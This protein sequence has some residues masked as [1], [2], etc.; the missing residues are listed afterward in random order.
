MGRLAGPAMALRFDELWTHRGL[1]KPLDD[2]RRAQE[3]RP[4]QNGLSNRGGGPGRV[5]TQREVSPEP[6][7]VRG[8]REN[9]EARL[10]LSSTA[11]V[12]RV[13][14]SL[15]FAC[16]RPSR[17]CSVPSPFARPKGRTIAGPIARCF[18]EDPGD[19]DAHAELGSPAAK[20]PW[21]LVACLPS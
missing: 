6:E 1:G 8:P 18:G 17:R 5:E 7:G 10:G 15:A 2:E 21:P 4:I 19:P 16:P 11:T 12:L 13:N 20:S 9:A 3:A 14:S